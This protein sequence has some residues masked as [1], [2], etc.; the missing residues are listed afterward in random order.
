MKTLG[1]EA[2]APIFLM[3][4]AVK[5]SVPTT[6][7]IVSVTNPSTVKDGYVSNWA[8]IYSRRRLNPTKKRKLIARMEKAGWHFQ[9]HL[10]ELIGQL[11]KP[12]GTVKRIGK[13]QLNEYCK[14]RYSVAKIE[15]L[16][17]I[18][19]PR[20]FVPPRLYQSKSDARTYA[21]VLRECGGDVYDAQK[22]FWSA[23][24]CEFDKLAKN[25]SAFP[26]NLVGIDE[27][28]VSQVAEKGI[29]YLS[30][31]VEPD[32]RTY[33]DFIKLADGDS[34]VAE[35]M[36]D[37]AIDIALKALRHDAVFKNSLILK[38][39]PVCE[40]AQIGAIYW[41]ER[42]EPKN[43]PY[44]KFV[45][46]YR[47]KILGKAAYW[48]FVNAEFVKLSGTNFPA[49]LLDAAGWEYTP[50]EMAARGHFYNTN[51]D[52]YDEFLDRLVYGERRLET[53]GDVILNRGPVGHD[54]LLRFIASA[55][56]KLVPALG[57]I[58]GKSPI[59]HLFARFE[60]ITDADTEETLY[61]VWK[62]PEGDPETAFATTRLEEANAEVEKSIEDF[63]ATSLPPSSTAQV[64]SR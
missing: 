61:V 6:N 42:N 41:D 50:F 20:L 44:T 17:D 18:V 25:N 9:T 21:D 38:G 2:S 26:S 32:N 8:H 59:K 11:C 19:P 47:C 51:F 5:G 63:V 49:C 53:T 10:G 23:V 24:V 3:P 39:G 36:F 62:G 48:K 64:P 31:S 4:D 52:D 58:R 16:A 40:L 37:K 46:Q 27:G 35:A 54:V 12:D 55:H 30:E 34:C 7:E 15:S 43:T 60:K 29:K 33:E 14:L 13:H 56:G 28:T 57:E 1:G 22:M 45:A